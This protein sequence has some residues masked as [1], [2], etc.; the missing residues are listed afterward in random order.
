MDDAKYESVRKGRLMLHSKGQDG[1]GLHLT[2]IGKHLHRLKL[3]YG[4]CHINILRLCGLAPL[5]PEVLL[6]CAPWP[7]HPA[8]CTHP[9][10]GECQGAEA[11]NAQRVS[12]DVHGQSQTL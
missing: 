11:S 2:R 10:A 8:G 9:T 4:C 6:I 3:G 7:P 1:E 5:T 12:A